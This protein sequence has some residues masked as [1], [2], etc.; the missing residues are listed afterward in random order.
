[1][2]KIL[3]GVSLVCQ[4]MTQV[5]N[6]IQSQK[7]LY[8]IKV[9]QGT[10]KKGPEVDGG[11]F[12]C[13]LSSS[14]LFVGP[15]YT[16]IIIQILYSSIGQW[17]MRLYLLVHMILHLHEMGFLIEKFYSKQQICVKTQKKRRKNKV[18]EQEWTCEDE[19]EVLFDKIASTDDLVS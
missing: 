4:N 16:L 9:L 12:P 10:N 5:A 13:V 14:I 19:A 8:W 3:E 18:K 11:K 1:M 2:R 15:N 7:L 17:D 6:V